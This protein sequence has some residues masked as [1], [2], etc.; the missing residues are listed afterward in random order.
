MDIMNY[1]TTSNNPYEYY[2]KALKTCIKSMVG[3]D[4]ELCD[5][6]YKKRMEMFE[7]ANDDI[8]SASVSPNNPQRL[9]R[10]ACYVSEY[11][12]KDILGTSLTDDYGQPI[13]TPAFG[14]EYYTYDFEG[15]FTT[16][17]KPYTKN[18]ISG[19]YITC[20][21]KL[22]DKIKFQPNS[23]N[24]LTKPDNFGDYKVIDFEQLTS[25]LKGDIRNY[26]YKNPDLKTNLTPDY[27]LQRIFGKV[28]GE[29]SSSLV[30]NTNTQ[31]YNSF[32][33]F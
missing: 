20:R 17:D 31:K 6:I 26:Y 29:L 14:V 5:K 24:K 19:Y 23:I 7:K 4:K 9:L 25:R 22:W 12:F 18:E 21:N 2:T 10:L 32:Y 11:V 33:G 16:T 1:I 30:K 28:L 15:E 27:D 3:D 8:P 13:L